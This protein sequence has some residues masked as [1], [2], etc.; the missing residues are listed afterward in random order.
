MHNIRQTTTTHWYVCRQTWRCG[1]AWG[2]GRRSP[3][4]P[5]PALCGHVLAMFGQIPM[6]W[7]AKQQKIDKKT[8]MILTAIKVWSTPKSLATAT[9]VSR[10]A[11]EEGVYVHAYI[12]QVHSYTDSI[13]KDVLGYMLKPHIHPP[14]HT[15]THEVRR[16][17]C[18]QV[19]LWRACVKLATHPSNCN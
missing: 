1:T 8:N 13:S 15:H 16:L 6:H 12:K 3:W 2:R 11:M 17:P 7:N 18:I 19:D 4:G 10:H 14:T 9:D 5:G